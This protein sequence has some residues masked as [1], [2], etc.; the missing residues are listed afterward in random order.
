MICDCAKIRRYVAGNKGCQAGGFAAYNT[1][2]NRL[3]PV[4]V[5][6]AMGRRR[7]LCNRHPAGIYAVCCRQGAAQE[8]DLALSCGEIIAAAVVASGIREAGFN[9]VALTGWQAGI[10][11]DNNFGQAEIIRIKVNVFFAVY[12]KES[13]CY[14]RISGCY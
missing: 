10:I 13:F 6:S 14:C 3:F 9:A 7:R 8:M 4:V 1:G 2:K 12:R 5:V 11:T